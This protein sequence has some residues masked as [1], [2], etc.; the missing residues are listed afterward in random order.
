MNYYLLIP[1]VIILIAFIPIKL[2]I[3]LSFN[4]LDFSGAFG[5]FL[6]KKEVEHQQFWIK[7][8]KIL[9]KKEDEIESKEI[10]FDSQEVIFLETLME[11]IKD[12]TR[13]RELFII[14]NIGFNDA[15]LSGLIAGYINSGLYIF[16]GKIKNAKPT[17]TMGIFDTISYNREVCQFAVNSTLSISLFDIVYSL[18]N[19]VILSK[20]KHTQKSLEKQS[21]T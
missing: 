3:K 8:K 14:Y 11:Q 2:Q 20:K 21:K 13:L 7:G 17:A 15:F 1:F 4:V 6:F 9:T 16:L 19:S 10:E 5:I 12:K 18:F